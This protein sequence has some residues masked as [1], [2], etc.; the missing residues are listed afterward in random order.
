MKRICSF[1]PLLVLLVAA[2]AQA[3]MYKWVGPDGK[4]T[5]SDTPPPRAAS[6]V[7]TKSLPDNAPS[8]SGLPFELAEAVK[9]SPVTLY[10]AGDCAPCEEGRKLLAGRGIPFS[11]KTVTSQEDLAKLRQLDSQE[12]IPLLTVGR[13]KERGFEAGAWNAALTAAGY[14]RSNQLPKNYRQPAAQAVVPASAAPEQAA[15]VPV[16]RPLTETRSDAL[17]PAVGNPPPGFRF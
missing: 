5:Y 9:N 7:E 14:P 10:T 4:I 8:T 17:P 11:E 2:G 16:D 15:S 13:S 12:R 3:Q 6:R 1:T